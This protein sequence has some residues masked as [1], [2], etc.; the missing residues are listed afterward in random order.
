MFGGS[1]GTC[2]GSA[3]PW[4]DSPLSSTSGAGVSGSWHPRTCRPSGRA[5]AK[6]LAR[7]PAPGRHV[8]KAPVGRGLDHGYGDV[9]REG[10]P[11]GDHQAAAGPQ[12]A[13]ELG[14]HGLE[15]GDVHQRERADHEVDVVVGERQVVQVGLVELAGG[16]LLSCALQHRAPSCPRR[17]PSGRASA[18]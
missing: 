4:Y 9:L 3:P 12:H 14:E 18:R 7:E 15:V 6:V 1:P 8:A 16:H 17:S 11:V 13:D 10:A 2:F 5:A